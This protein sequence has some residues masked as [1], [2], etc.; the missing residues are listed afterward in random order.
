MEVGDMVRYK[1]AILPYSR[2][3]TDLGLV[4]EWM[5]PYVKT[6]EPY[7]LYRILWSG[8]MEYLNSSDELSDDI[9]VSPDDLEVVIS[10]IRSCLRDT[11]S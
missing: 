2:V 10:V 6:M 8:S 11:S 4:V 5:P 9:W 7:G 3:P 1:D